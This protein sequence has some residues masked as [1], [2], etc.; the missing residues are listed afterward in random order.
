VH[1]DKR[2]KKQCKSLTIEEKFEVIQG[3]EKGETPSDVCCAFNLASSAV[4]TLMENTE[5]TKQ[6]SQSVINIG[7]GSSYNT[8]SQNKTVEKMEKL[9]V[10]W[11]DGM[12][13]HHLPLT[14]SLIRFK[15]K[16]LFD[17]LSG[18]EGGFLDSRAEQKSIILKCQ[19]QLVLILQLQM[20]FQF[21]F[22]NS[23][24]KKSLPHT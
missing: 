22:K 10:L 15:A 11:I 7:V 18:E 17:E 16:S 21:I 8:Y 2:L 12:T 14:E 20:N 19:K 24:M 9:L 6:S 13:P 4:T 1:L 5:T 3:M 23:L